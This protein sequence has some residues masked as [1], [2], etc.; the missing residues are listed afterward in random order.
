MDEGDGRVA[1]VT[2]ASSGL[3][4]HFVGVLLKHGF[5]VAATARRQ[6]RLDDLIDE[7]GAVNLHVFSGD[8]T[9]EAVR[10]HLMASAAERFGGIDVLINNAG[11]SHVSPAEDEDV[12]TFTQVIA[13]N[14]VATF[15]CSKEVFTYMKASRGGSIVNISSVL[16]LVGI[17]RIPQAAYCAGKGGVIS[18]TR[19]LAAQWARYGIRVNC[20]A[21]G[22]FPSEMTA[23][24]MVDDRSLDFIKR[25]VPVGRPGTLDELSD[26][27]IFLAGAG[28][29][30][31]TGQTIAVDGG[32]S[33]T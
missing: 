32:W 8:I 17:G 31:L 23:D 22:W 9:D 3:G 14:L 25:T 2:G 29:A 6:D 5:R 19:E 13:V 4:R 33:T 10:A 15:A 11:I 28:P 7:H 26:A 20:I 27:L 16:G 1:V 18:L 30:Y 24:M 12:T 21:P